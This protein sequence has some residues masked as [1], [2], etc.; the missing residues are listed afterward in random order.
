[1]A[2]RRAVVGPSGS[3][4]G[5]KVTGPGGKTSNHKTQANAI[6]QGKK[7]VGAKGG[8]VSIQGRDGKFREGLTVRPGNDPF[9]PK[10]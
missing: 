7:N 4:K 10:G 2:V 1:V 9:P 3:G 8:E 6:H 5:W